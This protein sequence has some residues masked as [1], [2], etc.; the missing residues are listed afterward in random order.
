MNKDPTVEAARIAR[1][2]LYYEMQARLGLV[3]DDQLRPMSRAFLVVLIAWGVPLII[4]V[5]EGTALGSF[6]DMPFL[7]HLPV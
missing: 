6:A 1:G 3:K 5:F 4:S 2:G 7:L